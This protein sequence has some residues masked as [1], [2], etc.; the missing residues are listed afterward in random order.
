MFT[1]P[2]YFNNRIMIL[3]QDSITKHCFCNSEI[4]KVRKLANKTSVEDALF[5][6]AIFIFKDKPI[7][8]TE[9]IMS[10]QR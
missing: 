3:F 6:V 5:V 2:L 4:L 10:T 9:L 8:Q 1:P 7:L